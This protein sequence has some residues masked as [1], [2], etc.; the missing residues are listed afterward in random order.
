M[1]LLKRDERYYRLRKITFILILVL[2]K[3]CLSLEEVKIMCERIITTFESITRNEDGSV[4][5][6]KE[7]SVQCYMSD[8]NFSVKT[9]EAEVIDVVN[10]NGNSDW[11]NS[12][13]EID[14]WR[15]SSPY[16]S[17]IPKGVKKIFPKLKNLEIVSCNLTKLEKTDLEQFGVD[18][19]AAIFTGNNITFLPADL[20]DHNPNI[21]MIIFHDCPILSIDPGFFVNLRTLRKIKYVI[22]TREHVKEGC[23]NQEYNKMRSETTL[24]AFKWSNQ[25]CF[26]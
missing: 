18:L 16:M 7:F 13:P 2:I 15:V 19:S 26:K 22:L 6:T 4:N 17:F 25:K 10:S 11:S 23:M 1:L 8:C 24:E 9:P 12:I 14:S 20:F 3:S 21:Q 5:E